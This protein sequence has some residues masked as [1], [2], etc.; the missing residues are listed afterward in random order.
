M[1]PRFMVVKLSPIQ[2]GK[3]IRDLSHWQEDGAQRQYIVLAT[4]LKKEL[5]EGMF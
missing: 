2:S 1:E 4:E 5:E 3:I